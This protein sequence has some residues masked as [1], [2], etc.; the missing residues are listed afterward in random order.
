MP[1]LHDLD[2]DALGAS[3]RGA[4]FND[5]VALGKK[6]GQFS[7]AQR[8]GRPL[9]TWIE[10]RVDEPHADEQAAW[11]QGEVKATTVSG[12]QFRRQRTHARVLQDEVERSAQLRGRIKQITGHEAFGQLWVKRAR[13]RH[14]GRSDVQSGR[15]QAAFDRQ[16]H[17]VPAAASGHERPP[18]QGMRFEILFHRRR[19]RA[20]IPE[21]FAH[22]VFFFPVHAAQSGL[23]DEGAPAAPMSVKR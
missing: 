21:G 13:F 4:V 5:F 11:P 1:T 8:V 3:R 19:G 9:V 14:P 10:C 2:R 17:L 15:L 20:A 7:H 18:T 16:R 12:A 23:E 22:L 6:L